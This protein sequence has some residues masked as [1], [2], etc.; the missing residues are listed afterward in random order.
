V[1][2]G[3]HASSPTSSSIKSLWFLVP[4]G[5][6]GG[7]EVTAEGP[8]GSAVVT[9]PE[10]KVGGDKYEIL[11]VDSAEDLRQSRVLGAQA[12][13]K[14]LES[15]MARVIEMRDGEGHAGTSDAERQQLDLLLHFCGAYRDA[16][17]V[18]LRSLEAPSEGFGGARTHDEL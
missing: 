17:H 6:I 11:F 12:L 4:P 2:N 3:R 8:T 15:A 1:V 10:G 13:V 7:E 9:L 18:A 14:E 16:L 5:V